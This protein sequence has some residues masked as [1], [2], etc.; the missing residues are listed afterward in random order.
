MNYKEIEKQIATLQRLL[1]EGRNVNS[2]AL[3]K[4][5]GGK[6]RLARETKEW[7]QEDVAKIL[8]KRR[9]S[10]TNIEAGKQAVQLHD[11]YQLCVILSIE[12]GDVLPAIE[13]VVKT[14][15]D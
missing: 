5:I 14:E 4:H 7:T 10:L 2:D 1:T 13:D 12:I 15:N 9:T 6:I 3:Y 8:G 11:L